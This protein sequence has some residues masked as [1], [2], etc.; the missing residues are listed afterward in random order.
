MNASA[1]PVIKSHCHHAIVGQ[2]TTPLLL[3]FPLL[4]RRTCV[5]VEHTFL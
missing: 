3:L 2:K 5:R 4:D 1:P